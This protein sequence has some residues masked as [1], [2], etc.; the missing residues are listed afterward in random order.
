MKKLSIRYLLILIICSVTIF[1]NQNNVFAEQYDVDTGFRTE[2]DGFGFENYGNV[3]CLDKA[4]QQTFPIE[5]LTA[6]EM[7]R[8][9]G[10][11]VCRK[12][13]TDGSCELYKVAELWMNKVNRA[14]SGGHCEGMAVLST[15]FYAGVLDP[16]IFGS[17]SV[18]QLNL[19]GNTLLQR[20]IAY[21][22]A[23]Q[24]FMDDYM[25]EKDPVS[26]LKILISAYKENPRLLIPIAIYQRNY[27]KGHTVLAYAIED[28][29]NGI[30]WLE[31]YDSNYPNQEKHMIIDVSNNSWTYTTL[32]FPDRSEIVYEGIGNSNPFQLAPINSRLKQYV[33][34]FC[35]VVSSAQITQPEPGF[36]RL[37]V[38]SGIN[39]YI[40]NPEGQ[41]T[42]YDWKTGKTY[43]EIPDLEINRTMRQTSAQL[44][45]NLPYYLWLNAPDLHSWA[46]FDVSFTSQGTVL[47]L[48]N[49]LESYEYPNII[50]KPGDS[51]QEENSN[52][53]TFEVVAFPDRLPT[54]QFVISNEQG[55]C[56]FDL[57]ILF[58]GMVDPNLKVDIQIFH[59]PKAGRFGINIYPAKDAETEQYLQT[60]FTISG[61]FYLYT[62]QDEKHIAINNETPIEMRV[63]GNIS[64]DYQ[65]WQKNGTFFINGDLDGDS[66]VEI[67]KEFQ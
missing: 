28:K 19:V 4:C 16:N 35:P 39:V 9:F 63:N 41:K 10:D 7:R 5:N 43:A 18:N 20:E 44:P 67:A 17:H 30:Y 47:Y 3:G 46:T 33:C 37:T 21:W 34:D 24:W 64:I 40:E 26:Q 58:K 57:N 49:V 8:L 65:A 38:D 2:K 48:Q 45:V 29:G 6:V 36:N 1:F 51:K 31:V 61:D 22:F 15:L 13:Q 12:I 60:T 59:N 14:M 42:G 56:R 55:E 66:I 52:T 11:R 53:E 23:T 62:D 25:I 54:V 27:S 32:S 50:Y